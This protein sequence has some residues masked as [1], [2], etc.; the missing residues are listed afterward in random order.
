MVRTSVAEWLEYLKHPIW[1]EP[2]IYV[3]DDL[4]L[5]ENPQAPEFGEN[6]LD[7]KN[8]IHMKPGVVL[9]LES[10]D[11]Y[12]PT[13][14]RTSL[15]EH[16]SDWRHKRT[17]AHVVLDI[18]KDKVAALMEVLRATGLDEFVRKPDSN[19]AVEPTAPALKVG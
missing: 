10:G 12:D 15:I 11:I 3:D 14:P 16:F 1:E 17:H 6:I 5:T 2:D 18:P 7:A 9:L 4:M 8:F 19:P 13:G